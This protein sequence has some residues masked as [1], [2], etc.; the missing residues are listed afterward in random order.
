MFRTCFR[1]QGQDL[2]VNGL[3]VR[4]EVVEAVV[5][6]QGEIIEVKAGFRG[7][8]WGLEVRDEAFRARV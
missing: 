6:G 4:H 5:G 7:Q 8:G 1:R 2:E 3:E